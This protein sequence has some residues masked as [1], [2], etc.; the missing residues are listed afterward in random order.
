MRAS[1]FGVVRPRRRRDL[2]FELSEG[3]STWKGFPNLFLSYD[4]PNG[5]G[6]WITDERNGE[7]RDADDGRDDAGTFYAVCA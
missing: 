2:A 3:V 1:S 7:T 4:S 5:T 6:V